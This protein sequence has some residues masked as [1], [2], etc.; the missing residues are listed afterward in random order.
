MTYP[1]VLCETQTLERVCAGA[2]IA[3]YGDGELAICREGTAKAQPADRL[4]AARLRHILHAS[5]ECLVGLPNIRSKTPKHAYWRKYLAS[6]SL[7][8]DRPYVSSFITRPDSAPWID[9]NAYW[10]RLESL[11][12]GQAVTLVRGS[13]TSLTA[14]DL[15]GAESE[16]EVL[17][18]RSGAWARRCGRSAT[19][20]A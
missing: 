10:A 14:A 19:R 9:T 5:G 4:L 7:L 18:P 12:I 2:S 15:I 3:R 6:A 13:E 1:D 11:W 16:T 20:A 8:A 17:A